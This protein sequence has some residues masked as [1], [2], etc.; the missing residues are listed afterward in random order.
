MTFETFI[1]TYTP[2]HTSKLSSKAHLVGPYKC[3]R[4]L[5]VPSRK[6]RSNHVTDTRTLLQEALLLDVYK[7]FLAKVLHLNKSDTHNGR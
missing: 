7:E 6:T 5:V 4:D 2:L 3:R 1:S